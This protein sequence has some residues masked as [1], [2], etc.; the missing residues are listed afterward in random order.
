M[1]VIFFCPPLRHPVMVLAVVLAYRCHAHTHPEQ[2]LLVARVERIKQFIHQ[3][4]RSVRPINWNA[5][6]FCCQ[7]DAVLLRLCQN[8]YFLAAGCR[9]VSTLAT[10]SS[11]GGAIQGEYSTLQ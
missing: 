11:S 1:S 5:V 6:P 7:I 2:G 4:V 3:R 9:V 10:E 8:Y